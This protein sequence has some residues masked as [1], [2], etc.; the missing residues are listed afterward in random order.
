M[1]EEDYSSADTIERIV[2][3][4]KR[5]KEDN[6]REV[7]FATLS[8]NCAGGGAST[9]DISAVMHAFRQHKSITCLFEEGLLSLSFDETGELL[10]GLNALGYKKGKS[11][12][13]GGEQ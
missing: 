13:M 8:L 3:D 6:L 9:E 2:R 4:A 1:K 12:N 7:F 10:Y 11:I 5:I